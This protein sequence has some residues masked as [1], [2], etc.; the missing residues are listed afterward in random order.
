MEFWL[1]YYLLM[2][3]ISLF[4]VLRQCFALLIF[5]NVYKNR[6]ASLPVP[7]RTDRWK[8]PGTPCS[9]PPFSS[10]YRW[11]LVFLS[12][13]HR[14]LIIAL[15]PYSPS[16]CCFIAFFS[17]QGF[18]KPL[19][20]FATTQ[21]PRHFL[22]SWLAICQRERG[23]GGRGPRN[24]REQADSLLQSYCLTLCAN[25]VAGSLCSKQVGKLNTFRCSLSL[26]FFLAFLFCL[27]CSF[28]IMKIFPP[29]QTR[30]CFVS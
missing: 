16:C 25:R 24:N 5:F 4:H 2:C 17:C 23:R 29:S 6:P 1:V 20:L 27:G 30:W 21:T 12:G 22:I 19:Y 10:L 11:L 28:F 7:S 26:F 18:N 9:P 15:L 8:P 14:C 3:C 13:K